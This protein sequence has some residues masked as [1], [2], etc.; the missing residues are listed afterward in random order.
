LVHKGFTL[1]APQTD[2]I[3]FTPTA[4]KRFIVTD[5]VA[6]A[7]GSGDVRMFDE[8]DTPDNWILVTRGIT[9]GRLVSSNLRSPFVSAAIGNHIRL[10]LTGLVTF[11]G[12]VHGYESD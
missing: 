10:T 7:G 3:I 2:V 11:D 1:E 8:V 4:G 5:I 12:V 9:V 6:S